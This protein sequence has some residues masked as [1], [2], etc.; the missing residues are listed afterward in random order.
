[1][2]GL[3]QEGSNFCKVFSSCPT[4]ICAP[5]TTTG[6]LITLVFAIINAIAVS[7][8]SAMA[9]SASLNPR[10]VVPFLLI[11]T[12]NGM[13]FNHF[14]KVAASMPDFLKSWNW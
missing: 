5:C 7:G 2:T 1:M 12:S 10:Q 13:I 6:R 14:L 8:A 11:S 4:K 3:F 9:F